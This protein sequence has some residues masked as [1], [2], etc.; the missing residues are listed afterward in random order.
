[1]GAG[2]QAGEQVLVVGVGVQADLGG[3]VTEDAD[4]LGGHTGP[5]DDLQVGQTPVLHKHQIP[6]HMVLLRA[7]TS[8][9][10]AG[11]KVHKAPQ[12]YTGLAQ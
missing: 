8:D 9:A 1:M 5:Q 11:S 7:R 10:G 3:L 2:R 4:S 12:L 6:A